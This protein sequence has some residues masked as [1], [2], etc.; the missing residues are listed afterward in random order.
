MMHFSAELKDFE[1]LREVKTEIELYLDPE[2]LGD[3][4]LQLTCLKEA[5]DH[6]HF[7]TPA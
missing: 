2:G 6:C 1:L 5:G 4:L 3:L 7:M